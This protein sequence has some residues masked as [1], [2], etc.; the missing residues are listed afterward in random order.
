MGG[1]SPEWLALRESYDARARNSAVFDA[2]LAS[3][4]DYASYRIVDLASGLGSTVRALAPHLPP[5]QAWR[6]VDNNRELLAFAKKL[7]RSSAFEIQAFELD[8]SCSLNRA[9]HGP[10][11]LVTAFALLDLVSETWL[12]RLL[13]ELV[14]RSI[15]FYATLTYD[16][17]AVMDPADRLDSIVLAGADRDQR[18]DKG[19]GQALGPN[20]ADAAVENLQSMGYFVAQGVSDW[21]LGPDDREIQMKVF[22]TWAHAACRTG[23]L[24]KADAVGWLQRRRDAVIAGCSSV[25]VGHLDFFATPIS[26]SSGIRSGP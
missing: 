20:A 22:A 24:S 6:L 1:F 14:R 17:R 3:A 18:T 9:L 11:D 8:L 4:K 16:G 23:D 25:R 19:F 15:P 2:V 7:T 26:P 10:V 13:G 12:E 21:V 5:S